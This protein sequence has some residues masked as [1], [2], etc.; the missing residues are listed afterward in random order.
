MSGTHLSPGRPCT[1]R[2][3]S[4]P[5]V[6]GSTTDQ[7]VASGRVGGSRRTT[8]FNRGAGALFTIELM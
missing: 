4:A 3:Q 2:F 1:Y 5:E 6:H 8:S 7:N